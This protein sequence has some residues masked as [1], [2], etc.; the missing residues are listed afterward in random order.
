MRGGEEEEI[1][2]VPIVKPRTRKTTKPDRKGKGTAISPKKKKS[3][4]K[5]VEVA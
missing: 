4:L 3:M 1:P 2:I 5:I